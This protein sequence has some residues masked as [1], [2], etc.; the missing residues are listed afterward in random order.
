MGK[1]DKKIAIVTGG[2]SGIG[3]AITQRFAEEGA[4]VIIVGRKENALKDTAQY[5]NKISYVVGDIT[6]AETIENIINTVREKYDGQLDILVNNAGW[7]GYDNS[8]FAD[9]Y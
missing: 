1:L 3:R 7:C 8:R 4:S 6:K 9:D 5:N 2:G